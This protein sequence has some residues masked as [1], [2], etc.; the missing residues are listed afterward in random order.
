M[1][2]D[3]GRPQSQATLAELEGCA[4]FHFKPRGPATNCREVMAAVVWPVVLPSFLSASPS[5]PLGL[6]EVPVS[7]APPGA[8][9]GRLVAVC[10]K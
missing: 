7:G 8:T 4:D 3:E 9:A 5:S 1:G 6:Y 2:A 10:F